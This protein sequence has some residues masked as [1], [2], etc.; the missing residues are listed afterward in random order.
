MRSAVLWIRSATIATALALGAGSSLQADPPGGREDVREIQDLVRK[1]VEIRT[2]RR[3]IEALHEE[4]RVLLLDEI[5]MLEREAEGLRE[6]L[7]VDGREEARIR[8]DLEEARA[9]RE[10]YDALLTLLDGP[11]REAEAHL[12][13]WSERLPPFLLLPLEKGFEKL[14]REDAPPTLQTLSERLQNVFVLYSQ[15]EQLNAAV[16]AER[17]IV[18]DASGREREM[19]VLLLGLASALAVSADGADAARGRLGADRIAWEWNA[20]LAKAVRAAWACYRKER[21]PAFVP[22][23]LRVERGER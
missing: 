2:E 1:W 17:M 13:S 12:R 6:A 8:S 21:P 7:D 19:D 3:R 5:H 11:L 22:I 16:H 23:P 18:R 14:P 4:E 10:R 20:S 15:L 9:A